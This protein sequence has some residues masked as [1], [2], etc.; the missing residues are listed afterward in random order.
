M[1]TS[2]ISSLYQAIDLWSLEVLAVA[3]AGGRKDVPCS[4]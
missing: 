3:I 2:W 4:D 1:G